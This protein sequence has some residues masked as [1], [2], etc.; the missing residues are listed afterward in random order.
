M[1]EN[2]KINLKAMYIKFCLNHLFYIKRLGPQASVYGE[3][4][5]R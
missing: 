4:M 5:E 1:L 2:H 3:S